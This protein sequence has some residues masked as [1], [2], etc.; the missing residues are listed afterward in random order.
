MLSILIFSKDRPLQLDGL[1]RSIKKNYSIP[2]KISV[3]WK[4]TEKS[5]DGY[6]KVR[7]S[8]TDVHYIEENLFHEDL[9]TWLKE[10]KTEYFTL[11]CD[12]VLI[13]G[14]IDLDLISDIL[15]EDNELL[16]FSTRLGQN[17]T[18]CHPS[19]S[20]MIPPIESKNGI[21]KWKYRD[22]PFQWD[23]G[24]PFEVTT[25]IYRTNL[26]DVI[27]QFSDEVLSHPNRIEG[28]I[29]QVVRDNFDMKLACYKKSRTCTITVNRVQDIAKNKIYDETSAD[30]LLEL[31]ALGKKLDIEKYQNKSNN[32]ICI[33][34]LHLR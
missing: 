30:R 32:S 8:H 12:D 26:R 23:W 9:K 34:D 29:S 22:Y 13:T 31:W 3:L 21:I 2:P 5:Y 6:C 24:Y 16:G 14:N 11:S 25:T 10:I 28:P 20:R 19:D 7:S 1:L 33:G 4:Y 15:K 17:I 27:F 18:Y